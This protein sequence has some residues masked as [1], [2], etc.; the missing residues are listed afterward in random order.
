MHLR[1][2]RE[3]CAAIIMVE[4]GIGG[5]GPGCLSYCVVTALQEEWLAKDFQAKA[6]LEGVG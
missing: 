5:E 2:P 3:G 1:W 6:K 4:M